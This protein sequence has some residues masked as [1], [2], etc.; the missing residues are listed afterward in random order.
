MVMTMHDERWTL[1]VAENGDVRLCD[2]RTGAALR[3]AGPRGLYDALGQL[4]DWREGMPDNS[5]SGAPG[6]QS[7]ERPA[8][9]ETVYSNLVAAIPVDERGWWTRSEVDD[10]LSQWERSGLPEIRM[11]DT[12]GERLTLWCSDVPR[13][14]AI[15]AV[16]FQMHPGGTIGRK[17]VERPG[18]EICKGEYSVGILQAE[19]KETKDA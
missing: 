19:E 16:E 8:P 7:N 12:V 4:A 18:F 15:L 1:G 6:T 10:F 5:A 2:L 3:Y 13:A 14:A 17:V 11:T 9:P